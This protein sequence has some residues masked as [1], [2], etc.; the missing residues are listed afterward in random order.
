MPPATI[1]VPSLQQPPPYQQQYLAGKKRRKGQ[2]PRRQ[3]GGANHNWQGGQLFSANKQPYGGG[4]RGGGATANPNFYPQPHRGGGRGLGANQWNQGEEGR[5][6]RNNQWHQ[7]G[8]GQRGA[9]RQPHSNTSKVNLNLLYC[10]SCGYDVD[11]AIWQYPYK[12]TTHIPNVPC[13]K[14]HTMAGASMKAQ[15]KTLLDGTGAGI[16]WIL[17]Q[18]LRKANCVM[19]QNE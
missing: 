3:G 9:P 8:G 5:G 16:G 2:G 19:D 10:Y 14:A 15:H 12:K 11:H 6:D 18:Q 7:G 4:G 1:H 17:D 13:D